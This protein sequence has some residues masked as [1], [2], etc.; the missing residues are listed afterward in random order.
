MLLMRV[1]EGVLFH[2][3]F[4]VVIIIYILQKE[5]LTAHI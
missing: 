2:I 1:A 4:K 3:A 5:Q